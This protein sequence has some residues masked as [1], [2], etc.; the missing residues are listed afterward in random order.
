MLFRLCLFGKNVIVRLAYVA[1]GYY[2]AKVCL[3]KKKEKEN[4]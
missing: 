3:E 1:L 4:A 2:I